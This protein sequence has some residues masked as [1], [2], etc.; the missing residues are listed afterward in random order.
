MGDLLTTIWEDLDATQTP[1][2]QARRDAMQRVIAKYWKPV[3]AYLRA[4][5][6]NHD[7]AADLTQGFF[8]DVVLERN[9]ISKAD[10]KRGRFRTL[11]LTALD[12]Y[13]RDEYRRSQAKKRAPQEQL[14]ALDENI[15]DRPMSNN[16]QDLPD[17]AFTRV[18]VSDL[19]ADCLE[20]CEKACQADGMH[21][22]WLMFY[23]RVI[24]PIIQGGQAPSYRALADQNRS[25]ETEKQAANRVLSVRRRFAAILRHQLK[26]ALGDE[27]HIDQEIADLL[28]ELQ[29]G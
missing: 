6:R 8:T 22:H 21:T 24:E 12:N 15:H 7:Q 17:L 4:G 3:Y 5:G 10:Q 19:L 20:T 23:A 29:R 2:P 16:H 13:S 18:W 11:L 1:N 9:L 14:L 26:N 27:Q 28:T 25:V